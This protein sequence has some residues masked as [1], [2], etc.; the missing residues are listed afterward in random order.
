MTEP[1]LFCFGLGYT[2][3]RA[4]RA[5]LAQG[6]RVAGT[7]REP[8]KVE[9]LRDEGIEVRLFNGQDPLG[10]PTVLAGTTHLLCSVP[11]DARGDPVLRLHKADI[12]ALSIPPLWIGLL[13]TTGVYGDCGGAWIDEGRAPNPSTDDN[14]RRLAAEQAWLALGSE[15]SRSTQ[16]FRLAGIY[17]P[18]GRNSVDALI[19][20][21]ARRIVKPGQVFNRIHVDDL[22]AI[23]LASMRR[24]FAE[25]V[26]NICDDEPAPA[27][28]VV[29]YA[30][31][32][33]GIEPP[34]AEPFETAELAPFARRFYAENRRIRNDRIRRELDVEL[35][36][37]SYRE[38]LLAIAGLR[39]H[40]A[41]SV[42]AGSGTG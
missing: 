31:G 42:A 36:Y 7:C 40:T 34:P 39:A 3:L 19:T 41:S 21:R 35:R 9:R 29:T 15:L 1:R 26:F 8:A 33:L 14:R 20:G 22:V 18:G 32:L 25:R 2:G 28:E 24:P 37:P 5:A 17:G 12:A 11:P 6:W 4:A 23:L 10:D 27:D 16:V 38:G 13:S 30:A